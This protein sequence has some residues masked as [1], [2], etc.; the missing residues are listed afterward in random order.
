MGLPLPCSLTPTK[1]TAFKDC[2]Y[3]F[4]LSV[5][6]KIP[7]PLSTWTVKGMIAHHAL[8][9][10]YFC[11]PQPE[12][13]PSAAKDAIERAWESARLS[14]NLGPYLEQLSHRARASMF[15]EISDLVFNV[16]KVE[17]PRR[18]RTV[19]TELMLETHLGE[20]LAR[21]VIDR[22]DIDQAGNLIVVDYKTGKVPSHLREQ[23]KLSS[24]LFYAYLVKKVLGRK[25]TKVKLIYLKDSTVI[26]TEAT[27][28]NLHAVAIRTSAIWQAVRIACQSENF[29]P[30][31]S[32]LCSFCAYKERCPSFAEFGPLTS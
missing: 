31:P 4:R 29:R 28:Q 32:K 24:V 6:E 14:E 8:E 25:P 26:E 20:V 17:D 12:R 27:E 9:L 21:G 30:R 18:V 13:T 23:D 2:A 10:F 7:Q 22:L 16:F 19:A 5:I 3:A 15:N 1:V 11:H